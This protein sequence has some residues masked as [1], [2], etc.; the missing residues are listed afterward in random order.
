MQLLIKQNIEKDP[1]FVADLD[2]IYLRHLKWVESLPR[3]QPLYA[4]KSNYDC[5]VLK[6]MAYLGVGFDCSSKGEIETLIMNDISPERILFANPNKQISH[7]IYSNRIG[8]NRMVFDNECEL[9]KI[10]LYHPHAECILRIKC[11]CLPAKFGADRET[12]MQLIKRAIELNIDLIGISFYVGF[13]QKTT[14]NM[15]DAIRNARFLFDYARD[16]FGYVMHLLD[17]GG[18]Y[19][20]T[21]QTRGLF[22]QMAATISQV[23]DQYFPADFFDK[24][25]SSAPARKFQIIAELGTYY[26]SSAYTLCVNVTSKK[27][28]KLSEQDVAA[29]ACDMHRAEKYISGAVN[30][31]VTDDVPTP[32]PYTLD[33]SK[34]FIYCVND[35]LHAS[36]KWYNLNEGL[37]IFGN[38]RMPPPTT[39]ATATVNNSNGSISASS[40]TCNKL[41]SLP[42][43]YYSSIGGATCDSSDFILKDCFIPELHLEEFLIF[44]NMGSY[45][46]TA[47]AYFNDIPLP[48][49]IFVSTR[50]W[51][52]LKNCIHCKAGQEH[53]EASILKAKSVLHTENSYKSI[54]SS[55]FNAKLA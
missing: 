14:H 49:T 43:F 12:S 10:K 13:R 55:M 3:V 8:V 18:G 2:E 22:E 7:L 34:K 46:K 38:Q 48:E 15:V 42:P 41:D 47:A 17:I 35:S 36:F 53:Y 40:E 29:V 5:V 16:T 31:L 6:L 11:D 33:L 1:F 28:L 44:R 19:P 26:T 45:T 30:S 25:C 24:T 54:V 23:L 4:L 37:P 52:I 21:W 51:D 20:G 39:T 32:L 9:M 27:E 50:L